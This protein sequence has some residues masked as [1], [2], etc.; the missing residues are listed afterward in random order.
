MSRML[1][2]IML[3]ALVFTSSPVDAA[4]LRR[5]GAR[6]TMSFV[7]GDRSRQTRAERSHRSAG[8]AAHAPRGRT[9]HGRRGE[10]GG[11]AAKASPGAGFTMMDGVL[12]YP[13][14]ARFQPK[15]LK[16]R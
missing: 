4:R 14:P 9:G 16:R 13:A 10:E 15:V 7:P 5:G 8:R 12:T 2:A 6:Q 3:G 11:G 1:L